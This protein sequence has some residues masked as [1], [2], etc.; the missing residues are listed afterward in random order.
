ML[1][2]VLVL[3]IV[4]FAQSRKTSDDTSLEESLE[5][6]AKRSDASGT[7]LAGEALVFPDGSYEVD[8]GSSQIRWM[9][10]KKI[11]DA[12]HEG[13]IAIKSGSFSVVDGLV[14]EGKIV[15]DMDSIELVE[16]DSGGDRLMGHLR[17]DDFF[18]VSE[19]P[20]A[21]LDVTEVSGTNA[22]QQ[23]SGTL[24]IK[25]KTNPITF[26]MSPTFGPA[27]QPALGGQIV[28]DRSEFDVR[29]G[30][31]SFFDD[32]GDAIIKDEITLD[33]LLIATPVMAELE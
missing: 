23:I 12:S 24:T 15:V 27:D 30:S 5:M 25:G 21:I 10:E 7:R 28:I 18:S 31:E 3:A 26:E 29:F 19:Y 11:V 13:T 9:G 32:L 16:G 33:V 20:E 2:A 6:E 14:S 4:F 1:A 17:S 22:K 8:G